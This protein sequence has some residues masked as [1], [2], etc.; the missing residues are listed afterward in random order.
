MMF[1]KKVDKNLQ[2]GLHVSGFIFLRKQVIEK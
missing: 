2:R 1:L